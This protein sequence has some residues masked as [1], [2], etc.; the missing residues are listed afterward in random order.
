MCIRDSLEGM[1]R[2]ESR[3][4]YFGLP[5]RALAAD[6]ALL[7]HGDGPMGSGGASRAEHSDDW[8][9]IDAGARVGA[10]EPGQRD[11]VIR[12]AWFQPNYGAQFGNQ[13]AIMKT[14]LRLRGLPCLLYTSRCV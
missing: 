14:A 8:R 11:R 4:R 10:I 9:A 7:G 13:Q 12:Q 2:L 3:V 6:L 1:Y 5:T